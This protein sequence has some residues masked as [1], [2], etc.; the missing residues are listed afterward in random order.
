[1]SGTYVIRP[2]NPL[3]TLQRFGVSAETLEPGAGCSVRVDRIEI[4]PAN[5]QCRLKLEMVSW[6]G[7]FYPCDE[8]MET[9]QSGISEQGFVVECELKR[10]NARDRVQATWKELVKELSARQPLLRAWLPTARLELSADEWPPL[11]E[12]VVPTGIAR[13]IL[14]LRGVRA[15]ASRVFRAAV[16]SPVRLGIRIE[17]TEAET[18]EAVDSLAAEEARALQSILERHREREQR[19]SRD[20]ALLF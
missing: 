5:R 4:R 17:D 6:N 13:D 15:H 12:L 16:G 8:V 18:T 19:R 3:E 9:L 10:V 11:I 20:A 2:E 7:V 14:E 1:M